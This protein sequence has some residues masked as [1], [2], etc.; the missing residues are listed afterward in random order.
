M[1]LNLI[2][3]VEFFDLWGIDFM[4]PLPNSFD[5]QYILV[6]VNYVSRSVEAV[7]T[8]MNDNRVIIKFL[9]ENIISCFGA[10]HVI[11]MTIGLISAIGLFK[12]ECENISYL[13]KY[14]RHTILK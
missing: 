4:G 2:L 11:I 10:S 6:A 5:N 7:I 14:P 12:S 8:R 13:T 3:E 9:G 1:L